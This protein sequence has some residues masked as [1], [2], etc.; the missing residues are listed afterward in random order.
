MKQG[1][2]VGIFDADLY[3][4][5]LPTMISP[6]HAHLH[7]DQEDPNQIAPVM[8][9]GVKCMSYGFA[10]SSGASIMRGPM[11]SQIVTQ[12]VGQTNW[13]NLDYLIIDFP[14]GTGDIQLTLGQE[15]KLTAAVIVTTPQRLSY[16]DVIK[17][18]EMFDSL[19]VPT[20]SLVENMSFYQCSNCDEKHRIFGEGHTTQIKSNYGIQSSFEVPI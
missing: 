5:S 1:H 12:L 11:V 2:S 19:K 9:S 14:P 3:G 15:L 7:Q 4:P 6:E 18:I 17:G 10:S 20:V 13:G 8:F 16:V